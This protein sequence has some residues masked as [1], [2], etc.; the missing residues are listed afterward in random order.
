[1]SENRVIIALAFLD[2]FRGWGICGRGPRNVDFSCR[3]RVS[4]SKTPVC[5]KAGSISR[6]LY[7]KGPAVEAY[8]VEVRNSCTRLK[9]RLEEM[10]S[11]VKNER[12]SR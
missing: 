4:P 9:S 3:G 1:M 6:W 8:A 12:T 7:L 11:R 5:L 10:T 2:R